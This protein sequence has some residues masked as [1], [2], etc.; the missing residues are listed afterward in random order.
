MVIE[1]K[2]LKFRTYI[3]AASIFGILTFIYWNLEYFIYPWWAVTHIISSTI[4]TR[5][6]IA[7]E[8]LNPYSKKQ[9]YFL[10]FFLIVFLGT[11]IYGN[12]RMDVAELTLSSSTQRFSLLF[13][14]MAMGLYYGKKGEW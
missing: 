10:L 8:F 7:K 2:F 3:G 11:I 14:A 13:Y 6:E 9:L 4:K 1:K 12:A 5:T